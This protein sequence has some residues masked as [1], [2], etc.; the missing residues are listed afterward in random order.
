MKIEIVSLDR[1]EAVLVTSQSLG[2]RGR[3]R[4][5]L[6]SGTALFVPYSNRE[7]DLA[8]GAKLSVETMQESVS[9]FE[10]VSGKR[11]VAL[12]ELDRP[13]DFAVTGTVEIVWCEQVI[14]VDAGGLSFAVDTEESGDVL[15]RS[16]DRVSFVV[17]GLSLWCTNIW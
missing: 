6:G 13:G 11:A 16:G 17:Q 5:A 3:F 9:G 12:K 14:H 7:D 2:Y 8:Q 4:C 1:S 15:P 10:I